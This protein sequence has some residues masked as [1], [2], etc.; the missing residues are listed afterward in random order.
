MGHRLSTKEI[1]WRALLPFDRQHSWKTRQQAMHVIRVNIQASRR[2]VPHS[3]FSATWRWTPV[4]T[5]SRDSLYC[6]PWCCNT[7]MK[8]TDVAV[9]IGRRNTAS[10]GSFIQVSNILL[11]VNAQ[12]SVSFVDFRYM[13]FSW[14]RNSLLFLSILLVGYTK[15]IPLFEI[16]RDQ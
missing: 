5:S 4:S 8:M 3:H 2:I 16:F 7:F 14:T 12:V 15:P 6:C 1:Q 10:S 13:P 11:S 9:V